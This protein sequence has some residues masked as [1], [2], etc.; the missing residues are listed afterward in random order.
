M[1]VKG[2]QETVR[3]EAIANDSWYAQGANG[4]IASSDDGVQ[5][6]MD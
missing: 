2:S 4:A 1:A 6:G 3:L 5:G